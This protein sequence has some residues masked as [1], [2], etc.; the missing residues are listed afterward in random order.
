[1]YKKLACIFF[2]CFFV[3]LDSHIIFIHIPK[4]AG[5]SMNSMLRKQFPQKNLILQERYIESLIYG[6]VENEYSDVMDTLLKKYPI[7][8]KYELVSGHFPVWYLKRNHMHYSTAF[9]FTVL[10]DPIERVLSNHRHLKQQVHLTRS[11]SPLGVKPNLMCKMLASDYSAEGEDLLR[12]AIETLNELDAVLF[13]DNLQ[14]S[15]PSLFK[16]LGLPFV[17]VEHANKSIPMY[18][19]PKH[20][21]I[22]AKNNELDIRLYK[23]AVEHFKPERI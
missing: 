20:L 21:E 1:M 8:P 10:R 2:L 19:N 4:C 5:T 15:V 23:Y 11:S 12:Q 14:E 7:N 9:K 16:T 18:I 13:V 3:A 22:I 17:K 6:G